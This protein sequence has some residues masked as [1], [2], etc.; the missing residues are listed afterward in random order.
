MKLGF[1][2]CIGAPQTTTDL[3]RFVP[4]L[5]I[6][7]DLGALRKLKGRLTD[8]GGDKNLSLLD[9]VVSESSGRLISWNYY[10]DPRLNGPYNEEFWKQYF[11]NA[12]RVRQEKRISRT[13]MELLDSFQQELSCLALEHGRLVLQ[14]GA[15]L[16]TLMGTGDWLRH[17]DSIVLRVPAGRGEWQQPLDEWL[18]PNGFLK[19]PGKELSWKR[20]QLLTLKM[21]VHDSERACLSLES[22]LSASAVRLLIAN[23]SMASLQSEN[24]DLKLCNSETERTNS[25]LIKLRDK[26]KS[27]MV[28]IKKEVLD[29]NKE[30]KIAASSNIAFH[31]EVATLKGRKESL[32]NERDQL[33]RKVQILKTQYSQLEEGHVYLQKHMESLKERYDNLSETYGGARLKERE[34]LTLC[35]DTHKER[36]MLVEQIEHLRVECSQL[37]RERNAHKNHAD[38]LREERDKL[39]KENSLLAEDNKLIASHQAALSIDLEKACQAKIVLSRHRDESVMLNQQLSREQEKLKHIVAK[40]QSELASS[41]SDKHRIAEELKESL[42]NSLQLDMEKKELCERNDTL[43]DENE[44][45]KAHIKEID[46]L[47]KELVND[48]NELRIELE[49]VSHWQLLFN[50]QK[51]EAADLNKKSAQ[52]RESFTVQISK[53]HLDAKKREFAH[54]KLVEELKQ[55]QSYCNEIEMSRREL[56]GKINIL[57]AEYNSLNSRTVELSEHQQKLIAQRDNLKNKLESMAKNSLVTS[58]TIDQLESQIKQLSQEKEHLKDAI[59]IS[60]SK[61]MVSVADRQGLA[62]ELDKSQSQ[63]Q[64]VDIERRQ[65]K[66]KINDTISESNNLESTISNLTEHQNKLA[67]HNH[68]L[69]LEL[70]RAEDK[71]KD[72]STHNEQL[73]RQVE[74]LSQKQTSLRDQ[75]ANIK[76]VYESRQAKDVKIADN[77]K[78]SIEILLTKSV[79]GNLS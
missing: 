1:A 25:R 32:S 38:T 58:S 73:T 26:M 39:S 31:N 17:F 40:L 64:Q 36:D 3:P 14:K 5:A 75:I 57:T 45:L 67:R 72:I 60:E 7:A 10:N 59:A 61:L 71:S 42:A 8:R 56:M 37:N 11:P 68:N 35:E 69:K 77:I 48:R 18:K 34:L 66:E 76:S 15:P 41:V 54:Q 22:Y 53:L 74:Q 13:L 30:L 62:D 44:H 78:K 46:S 16:D 24:K 47:N 12:V 49:R 20:D 55:S 6:D 2:V 21:D 28:K 4:V 65:L 19:E 9:E 33:F 79:Q 52:E 23:D 29:L 70:I 43:G 51:K 63:F 27:N 50:R